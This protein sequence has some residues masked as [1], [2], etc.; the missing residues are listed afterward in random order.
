MFRIRNICEQD[1]DGLYELSKLETLINLPQDRKLLARKIENSL[2]SF[3][4]PSDKKSQ[5]HYIFVLE[6]LAKSK[7]IGASMIHGQHGTDQEPHFFFR[8]YQEEKFSTSI[9]MKFTH[10][11]LQLDYEPNGYSEIG[12]LILY[13]EYR[14]RADKLGKQLSFARFLYISLNQELFTN[15]IHTELQPPLNQ[16]GCPPLWRA[17]GKQFTNMD[18]KEADRLSRIDKE[19]I[20]NLFP[21][22]EK[23]Y[24]SLLPEEA[25]DAI[26]QVAP[27]ARPV[28]AMLEKIGFKYV[29]EIDPFDGG[30]HYRCRRD[31]IL[32]IKQSRNVKIQ[33]SDS[34]NN[35]A[36]QYL[37]QIKQDG[38]E[39]CCI[40]VTGN[41]DQGILYIPKSLANPYNIE[42][43]F[44]IPI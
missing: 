11:V 13:P 34:P 1:L 24:K 3:K 33:Y 12:G 27:N 19:F 25:R 10:D 9:N 35:S 37:V 29:G 8:I 4:C 5:N 17:I 18:Y 23:I 6:D 16:E 32:L 15:I 40:Q 21:W 44:C 38:Y 7:V 30:P 43:T 39:F 41:I 20:I 36:S 14:G 22:G 31:D 42:D 26:A 2:K 28:R